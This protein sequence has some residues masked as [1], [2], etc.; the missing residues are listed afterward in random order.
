M[1]PASSSQPAARRA[2]LARG[3]VL[4]LMVAGVSWGTSGT[5]G[6]L[7][8]RATGHLRQTRSSALVELGLATVLTPLGVLWLGVDGLMIGSVLSSAYRTG[9]LEWYCRSRLGMGGYALLG[10]RLAALLAAV[11]ALLIV[12]ALLPGVPATGV[13][14]TLAAVVT[15]VGT[16]VVLLATAWLVV[17]STLQATLTMLRPRRR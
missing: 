6:T 11:V 2:S 8:V 10:R 7:L 3:G 9:Y 13:G 14:W 17:R 15:A 16:A 4:L 5:L 12:A 1:A